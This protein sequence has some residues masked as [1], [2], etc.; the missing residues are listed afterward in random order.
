MARGL[1]NRF[2]FR[3]TGQTNKPNLIRLLHAF[4]AKDYLHRISSLTVRQKGGPET[5]Q[6]EMSVDAIADMD[7]EGVASEVIFHFSQNGENLP[8]VGQGLWTVFDFENQGY[9]LPM[10]GPD[11]FA[12]TILSGCSSLWSWQAPR[13]PDAGDHL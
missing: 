8:W 9:G 12:G 13:R 5:L 2:G 10:E 6:I 11:E 4:Y 3:V 1:Y 7:E